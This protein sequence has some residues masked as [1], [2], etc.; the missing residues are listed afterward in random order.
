M[1]LHCKNLN[2]LKFVRCWNGRNDANSTKNQDV[3]LTGKL[4]WT[5]VVI[6]EG[7][8]RPLSWFYAPIS[9]L[10]VE[11]L[12]Y[13]WEIGVK[14]RSISS[15]SDPLTTKPIAFDSNSFIWWIK[16]NSCLYMLIIYTAWYNYLIAL[17]TGGNHWHAKKKWK[18]VKLRDV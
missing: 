8:F 1:S 10:R 4:K 2:I 15:I 9:S 7:W 5:I 11:H 13:Y 12:N 16:N 14:A 3:I 6:N 18:N 17:K